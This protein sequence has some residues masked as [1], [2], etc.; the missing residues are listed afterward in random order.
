L[1]DEETVDKLAALATAANDYLV[2]RKQGRG[3]RLVARDLEQSP[4]TAHMRGQVIEIVDQIGG[5][6]ARLIEGLDGEHKVRRL[7]SKV[8]DALHDWLRD[9]GFIDERPRLSFAAVVQGVAARSR[10]AI[11]AG[12]LTLEGLSALSG[13]L[14][15][16]IAGDATTHNPDQ[17]EN[18]SV[19]P[20]GEVA[21]S[22]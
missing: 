4:L 13:V 14:E 17:P 22:T 3:R 7:Q 2:L 10:G 1:F 18:E 19:E 8:K 9:Q 12:S 20:F 11:E 16:G 15:Q 6:A 21:G 5:D